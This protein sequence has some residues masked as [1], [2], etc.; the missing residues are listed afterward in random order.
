M[1]IR[2]RLALFAALLSP[3]VVLFGANAWLV[4]IGVLLI[5][6]LVWAVDYSLTPNH[7]LVTIERTLPKSVALDRHGTASWTVTNG[8]KRPVSMTVADELA[9]SLR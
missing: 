4:L 6:G 2:R 8:A 3:A 5:V 1:I 9:P 7:A